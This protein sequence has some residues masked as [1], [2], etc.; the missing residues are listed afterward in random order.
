M[1]I[2]FLLIGILI[3]IVDDIID[4]NLL[5]N[6]DM[7][8]NVVKLLL[9]VMTIYVII[10]I[11]NIYDIFVILTFGILFPILDK[12][13]VDDNFWIFYCTISSLLA[14]IRLD[15][16]NYEFNIFMLLDILTV[17]GLNV[18]CFSGHIL[19]R[20]LSD[21]ERGVLNFFSY[22]IPD[23]MRDM[24]PC[25]EINIEKLI[26]RM[27]NIVLII[28][29]LIYGIELKKNMIQSILRVNLSNDAIESMKNL[30]YFSLGYLVISCNILGYFL[31]SDS[32]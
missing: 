8:L 31:V 11:R 4:I 27:W 24:L 25:T 16:F 15:S 13:S 29:M 20:F 28:Y 26:V 23:Y 2:Q 1:K 9:L 5:E 32:I 10:N 19:F 18:Q 12:Y 21:E 14:L 3:K 7:V 6:D 22:F 17:L 30:S